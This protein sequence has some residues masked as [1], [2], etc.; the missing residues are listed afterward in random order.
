MSQPQSGRWVPIGEAAKVLGQHP[1]TLRRNHP[2][3]VRQVG[4][5]KLW[6]FLLEEEPAAPSTRFSQGL[7]IVLD[8]YIE[9]QSEARAYRRLV[10]LLEQRGLNIGEGSATG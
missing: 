1:D 7:Q 6:Q 3:R 9:S 4:K 8:E 2:T 10:Q 5:R